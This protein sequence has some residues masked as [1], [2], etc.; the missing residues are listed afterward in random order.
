MPSDEHPATQPAD[1]ERP[2]G[3]GPLA[4]LAS[5]ATQLSVA[6]ALLGGILYVLLTW[7]SNWVYEPAGVR[8]SD[9]GLGYGAMLVGTAVTLVVALALVLLTVAFAFGAVWLGRKKRVLLTVSAI[10]ALF[11]LVAVVTFIDAVAGFFLG[12]LPGALIFAALFPA[13]AYKVIAIGATI[14]ALLV[15]GFTVWNYA[16]DARRDIRDGISGAPIGLFNSPWEGRIAAFRAM[17]APSSVHDRCG[18]YL[19]EANGIGVFVVV[20]QDSG[21]RATFRLPLSSLF[22]EI[23]PEQTQ[24]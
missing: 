22:M 9:V 5:N 6:G 20:S 2:S 21:Q 7:V 13:N 18:L 11:G 14:I 24:C 15:A 16:S 17:T 12:L 1:G 23:L 4:F 3:T 19:G 8:P 10:V